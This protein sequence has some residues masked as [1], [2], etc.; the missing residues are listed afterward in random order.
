MEILYLLREF[1]VLLPLVERQDELRTAFVKRVESFYKPAA[2]Y[3]LCSVVFLMVLKYL[4]IKRVSLAKSP[5]A[6]SLGF[7]WIFALLAFHNAWSF[8]CVA[9]HCHELRCSLLLQR[10]AF[11]TPT[12][13]SFSSLASA[14]IIGAAKGSQAC[15]NLMHIA[16]VYLFQWLKIS[17]ITEAAALDNL[18]GSLHIPLVWPLLVL[19]LA[20]AS[21]PTSAAKGTKHPPLLAAD[22]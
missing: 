21:H 22:C 5:P 3:P 2:Q 6:N 4:K 13:T 20:V 8:F 19:A 16:V 14:W 11:I 17:A 10:W 15:G 9:G 1:W 7:L 12:S 18:E